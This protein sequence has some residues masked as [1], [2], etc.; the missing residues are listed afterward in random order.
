MP[1]LHIHP[2]PSPPHRAIS[3]SLDAQSMDTH[4]TLHCCRWMNVA[5]C[6]MLSMTCINL[7]ARMCM[8]AYSSTLAACSHDCASTVPPRC[9]ASSF[10]RGRHYAT[11]L[12]VCVCVRH[13]PNWRIGVL[14]YPPLTWLPNTY[15]HL[16]AYT[17]ISVKKLETW[18]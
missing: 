7:S 1:E 11:H 9:N 12:C 3:G 2:S 4:C 6:Y 17:Q 16:Q 14:L 10:A 18:L 15:Y 13:T 8:K 5:P